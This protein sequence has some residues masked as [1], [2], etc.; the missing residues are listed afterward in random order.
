MEEYKDVSLTIDVLK[1][2]L[3]L[4]RFKNLYAGIVLQ[5]YLPDTLEL[6]KDLVY[7]AKS[8]VENGGAPVKVR[9]VKGANQ[10]MELTEASLRGWECVTYTKKSQSDA[11]YKVVMEYLLRTPQ[12]SRARAPPVL[13]SPHQAAAK[14]AQQT[15]RR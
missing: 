13:F 11:N 6:A 2:T 4:E 1:N 10:E 8:R 14:T 15:R 9:L 3:S 7:W 12:L 5:T